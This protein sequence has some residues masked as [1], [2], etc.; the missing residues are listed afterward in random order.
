MITDITVR[1]GVL[2]IRLDLLLVPG[3][4]EYGAASPRRRTTI[5]F[6]SV[7]EL[8][9]TGRGVVE[10]AVAASGSPGFGSVGSLTRDGNA[11]ELPDDWGTMLLMPSTPSL[12]VEVQ[13]SRKWLCGA[14]DHVSSPHRPDGRHDLLRPPAG[15]SR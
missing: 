10:P 3:H 5:A 11:Y 12:A 9:R 6:S 8:H 13:E 14:R 2:S 15:P 1:P 7:L 4:R